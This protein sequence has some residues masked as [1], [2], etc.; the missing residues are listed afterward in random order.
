MTDANHIAINQLT[1]RDFLKLCGASSFGLAL[2]ACGVA[3]TPT[4]TPTLTP[5]L[6]PT[7]TPLPTITQSPTA[8]VTLTQTPAPTNTATPT[9]TPTA[10]ATPRLSTLRDYAD[11]IGFE[12]GVYYQG[13]TPEILRIA[14]EHFNLGQIFV[15]W[16]YSEPSRGNFEQTALRYYT[17][18]AQRNRMASQAGMLVWPADLP[19]WVLRGNFGRDELVAVMRDHIKGVMSSYEGK[20]KEWFVVN[21]PYNLPYRPNDV[22]YQ[23]LGLEYIEI[24]FRTARETDPSAILIYN[25]APNWTSNGF[26]TQ[27]TR[28]IVQMLKPKGLIDGVGLQMHLL[29]FDTKPPDKNDVIATMRSYGVPIYITEFDVNLK[30]IAGTQEQRYAF[31]AKIYKDMLQACLES[32][33]CKS[34]TVFGITDKLSVWETLKNMQGYSPNADPLPFDDNL[35]PK[36]AYFAMLQV[37]QEYYEKQKPK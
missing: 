29:Q 20:V 17:N 19:D 34:F 28:Q 14:S 1:R 7:N 31:Q 33:V 15:G 10:T 21:E 16:Q 27:L 5:T 8:T 30:D 32:E 12:I 2:A 37:L 4:S 11:R 36:P 23:A 26:S 3:P 24:A 18:F 6:A 25:D 13:N 35:N 22:F 9:E